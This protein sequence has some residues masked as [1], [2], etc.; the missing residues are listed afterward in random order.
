MN[1]SSI[2]PVAPTE[3]ADILDAIRGIAI[4]GIFLNN[5]NGFSGYTFLNEAYKKLLPNYAIDN[6]L[7][8]L[9]H[10]LII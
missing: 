2:L 10:F 1:S 8:F 4:L 5:I 9:Q 6:V 3:R 7:N